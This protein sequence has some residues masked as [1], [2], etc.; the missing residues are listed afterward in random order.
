[1]HGGSWLLELEL[2]WR[3]GKG[4]LFQ[5]A[6]YSLRRCLIRERAIEVDEVGAVSRGTYRL[7]VHTVVPRDILN[8]ILYQLSF[9]FTSILL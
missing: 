2:L 4:I 5:L 9:M 1:M 7:G 8:V 6:N 3:G